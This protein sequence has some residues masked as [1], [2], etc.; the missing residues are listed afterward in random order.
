MLPPGAGHRRT[1]PHRW[2]F[3]VF[4]AAT[5]RWRVANVSARAHRREPVSQCPPRPVRQTPYGPCQAAQTGRRF[6][7]GSFGLVHP[8]SL[9]C[10]RL[11]P[12][13]SPRYPRDL[14]RQDHTHAPHGHLTHELL[15]A[16]ALSAARSKV[17]EQ[18]G[19]LAQCLRRGARAESKPRQRIT[20][21][22]VVRPERRQ[23]PARPVHQLDYP[24]VPIASS[25][26][27]HDPERPSNERMRWMV[28]RPVA[29]RL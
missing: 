17:W 9:V 12:R 11:H 16:A 10:E 14:Q 8:G 13:S 6:I 2:D 4:A 20:A 26:M 7:R 24:I 1:H 5:R 25:A 15:E 29:G 22:R 19:R 27:A 28:S 18:L 3:S 21:N 23:T